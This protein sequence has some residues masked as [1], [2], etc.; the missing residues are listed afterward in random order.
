VDDEIEGEHC[1][2]VSNHLIIY[3]TFQGDLIMGPDENEL[4][5]LE[6]IGDAGSDA[7]EYTD[8]GYETATSDS[9]SA[10]E[11]AGA[12]EGCEYGGQMYSEGAIVCMV[13]AHYT[14]DR[15]SDGGFYW[16][17]LSGPYECN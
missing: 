6:P 7:A 10:V 3:S 13:N 15:K 2:E 17:F 4:G 11:S 14:C 8:Q 1:E 12:C 9:S 5:L 16:R